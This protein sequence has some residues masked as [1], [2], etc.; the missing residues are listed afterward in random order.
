MHREFQSRLLCAT[1][2]KSV[3]PQAAYMDLG[4]IGIADADASSGNDN[5]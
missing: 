2:T 4:V 3:S 5:L 1:C